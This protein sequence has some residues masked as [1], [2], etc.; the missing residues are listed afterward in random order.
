MGAV[1]HRLSAD[2]AVARSVI[3]AVTLFVFWQMFPSQVVRDTTPAFSD[4]TGH[5]DAAWHFRHRLLPEG[6]LSGWT[7]GWFTGYPVGTFYFPL[8][9]V[10][11]AVLGTLLPLNVALKLVA[12]LGPLT[13][14]AA[15]Y[16]FGRLWGRDRLT[17]ACLA[18]AVLPMLLEPTLETPGGSILSA[19]ATGEY[20]YGL[21]LSVALVVLGLA[22]AGLRTGQYRA[23]TAGLLA[24]TV[25][26]HVLPAAFV[27]VGIALMVALRPSRAAVQWALSVGAVALA[28]A[29]VWLVPFAARSRFAGGYPCD[30]ESAVLTWLF[31]AGSAPIV[32]VA[33]LGAAVGI[34]AVAAGSDRARDGLRTFLV[35]MAGIGALAFVLAPDGRVCNTRFLPFWYLSICLLAGET[36]ARL[37]EVID[38][39]RK[40]NNRGRPLASPSLARLVMPLGLLAAVVPVWAS[41][42]GPGL[43]SREH[44]DLTLLPRATLAG[45]EGYRLYGDFRQLEDALHDVGRQHGCGRLHW[46]WTA[47][48]HP[49]VSMF[50]F[51]VPSLTKGCLGVA[52]GLY[53]ESSATEPYV[54]RANQWLS[55]AASYTWEEERPFDLPRGVEAL[56]ILGLRYFVAFDPTTQDAADRSPDLRRLAGDT[57]SGFGPWSIYEVV[58]TPEVVEPLRYAPVVIPGSGQSRA[59]WRRT[60]RTWFDGDAREVLPAADGPTSWPRRDDPA[61]PR[62]AERVEPTTVSEVHVE[63]GRI[64]FRVSEAGTPVL[65]KVS[66]FPNWRAHGAKGPWRVAPNQMVVVPTSHTVTL[67]YERTGVEDAGL[68][69][70]LAGVG[71]L[72]VL[73]RRPAL[74]MPES[75][76]DAPASSARPS[77]PAAGGKGKHRPRKPRRH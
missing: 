9:N 5:F 42:L 33:G 10:A 77:R 7:M 13:L 59:S 14:P 38:E 47:S 54:D 17:S 56:R 35:L 72:V 64:S 18:V 28:L 55:A 60:A 61:S 32:V 73:R 15:A 3:G 75:L 71:G 20:G 19:A 8:G 6:K 62:P 63:E 40:E 21:S 68:L 16:A 74:E 70:T 69:L 4:L 11:V 30:R 2:R 37:A 49:G 36:L 26:F 22:R 1:F 31:P 39:R 45:Y 23:L 50:M 57:R 29:G 67:R 44:A 12:T 76:K 46:E 65:V 66:Y 34:L 48:S 52:R 24:V 41:R 43:M 27:F 58:G 51:L 25:L 53:S